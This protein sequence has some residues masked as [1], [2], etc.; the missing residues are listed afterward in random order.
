MVDGP[1]FH[2]SLKPPAQW[3]TFDTTKNEVFH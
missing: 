1:V 3:K 2:A